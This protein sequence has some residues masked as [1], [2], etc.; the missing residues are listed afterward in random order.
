MCSGGILVPARLKEENFVI[1]I[2]V[3]ECISSH[4]ILPEQSHV[5]LE[6]ENL[7]Q[8]KPYERLETEIVWI[9]FYSRLVLILHTE[10]RIRN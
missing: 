5:K 9:D 6:F 2:C 1:R 7:I 8:K 4:A 10:L 3:F